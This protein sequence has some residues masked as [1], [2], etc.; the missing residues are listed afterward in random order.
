MDGNYS[1]HYE[2]DGTTVMN[3][4]NEDGA[5]LAWICRAP[6]FLIIV[7]FDFCN[8]SYTVGFPCKVIRGINHYSGFCII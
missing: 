4:N 1:V 3:F 8:K 6:K 7:T 2:N 5:S